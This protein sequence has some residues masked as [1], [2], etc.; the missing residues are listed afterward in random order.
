MF[1]QVQSWVSGLITPHGSHESCTQGMPTGVFNFPGRSVIYSFPIALH[2]I[3]CR[4]RFRLVQ[5][6]HQGNLHSDRMQQ[7]RP[8]PLDSRFLA[9]L[10]S[11][12]GLFIMLGSP[13]QA[14][15]R[16]HHP[17]SHP[18]M[19]PTWAL[20][21]ALQRLRSWFQ[22]ASAKHPMNARTNLS[23][24]RYA[25]ALQ[26]LSFTCMRRPLSR[27][28]CSCPSPRM[29]PP[30]PR[31]QRRARAVRPNLRGEL[32]QAR[33]LRPRAVRGGARLPLSSSRGRTSRHPPCTWA[34]GARLSRRRPSPRTWVSSSPIPIPQRSPNPAARLVPLQA[35]SGEQVS[36]C[37]WERPRSRRSRLEAWDPPSSGE[38]TQTLRVSAKS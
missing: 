36:G 2:Q 15:T 29:L 38:E 17:S 16:K 4:L 24:V 28:S 20:Q 26:A 35:V 33:D 5:P 37:G 31:L 10:Q 21:P 7:L 3:L 34:P 23:A 32:W 6:R 19:G 25:T 12:A 27:D 1:R 18:I 22:E 30:H 14:I 11:N 9:P 13:Q 8:Y